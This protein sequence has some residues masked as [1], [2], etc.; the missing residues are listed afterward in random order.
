LHVSTNLF[1]GS[2]HIFETIAQKMNDSTDK[3]VSFLHML[4]SIKETPTTLLSSEIL[5][6]YTLIL[7]NKARI[8]A[9]K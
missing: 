5:L 7:R 6:S 1:F 9:E 3:Q 2:W 4:N 8:M